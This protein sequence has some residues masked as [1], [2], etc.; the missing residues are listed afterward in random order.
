[1]LAVGI[2]FRLLWSW[3]GEMGSSLFLSPLL[4]ALWWVVLVRWELRVTMLVRC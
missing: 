2:P 1:M 4:V 3:F